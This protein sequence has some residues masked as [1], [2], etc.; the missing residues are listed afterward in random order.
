MTSG[1]KKLLR[2][3]VEGVLEHTWKVFLIALGLT[4]ISTLI[5]VSRFDIRSGL[6]DLMPESAK[7]VSDIESI[8]ARMGSITRLSI[9]LELTGE[10]TLADTAKD[11]PAYTACLERAKTL[12]EP[13]DARCED[14]LVIFAYALAER[15]ETLD[16][17][18]YVH[19]HNDKT[20]FE[21]NILLYATVEDL[22]ELYEDV[23]RKLDE[24]RKEIG[25]Y[26][27]CLITALEPDTQCVEPGS[28]GGGGDGEDDGYSSRYQDRLDESEVSFQGEYYETRLPDGADTL[29]IYVRFRNPS[30][31]YQETRKNLEGIEA[32][33]AEL[34]P[35]RFHPELVV[36]YGGGLKSQRD[37]YNSIIND[38]IFSASLTFGSIFLLIAFFFRRL[39]A[40][41][42]IMAPL[43]MS[44]SWTL[45]IAFSTVGYL[46]LITAFIF[47]VLLGLGI[48]FGIHILARYDEERSRGSDVGEAMTTA[49]V[50]VGSANLSGAITTSATFFT[51]M[52][53]DF[54]GFS[55]FGFVAGIGVLTALASMILVMPTVALLAHR[56]WPVKPRVLRADSVPTA[57]ASRRPVLI[58][59]S[60]VILLA[61]T[62][63]GSFALTHVDDVQLEDNFYRLRMRTDTKKRDRYA[64]TDKRHPSPA[65]LMLDTVD[66]VAH[67]ENR[68][69]KH[70]DPQVTW[71]HHQVAVT[72]PHLYT[73]LEQHFG[74]ALAMGGGDH[75]I[76]PIMATTT[77]I[78][79]H[80]IA[81]GKIVPDWHD[82]NA[83]GSRVLRDLRAFQ[84]AYPRLAQRL[85]EDFTGYLASH[86]YYAQ[87]FTVSLASSWYPEPLQ[88][89]VPTRY[90]SLQ[91][92][93]VTD[94]V[95]VFSFM[96][97]SEEEQLAKLE[98]IEKIR[99]R[100]RERR[101]RFLPP[102]DREE[103]EEL[104]TFLVEKPISVDDLPPWVKLQFRET[105]ATP[106]PPREGSGVD[107]AFGNVAFIYQNTGSLD[108][109]QTRRFADD[110]DRV[111]VHGDHVTLSA[112]ALVFSEII[113]QVMEDGVKLTSVVLL[114][115]I[116]V[117]LIQV[118][119][120]LR[121]IIVM[122]P[123][124]SSLLML[125]ACMEIFYIK[126]TFF[127]MVVL[128]MIIGIGIDDG[129]HLYHRY[130]EEG[131]G[132]IFFALRHTGG[133]IF[134]TSATTSIGFSGMIFSMH[135]G[136]N[137]MGE[138]A[139]L[140]IGLAW[141]ATMTVQP[142]LILLAE[143]FNL[144]SVVPEKVFEPDAGQASSHSG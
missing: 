43:L 75:G 124:F 16:F 77:Q 6:N 137:T 120:P 65:L 131:R 25:E 114:A 136:L 83:E 79:P 2:F 9:L 115:V 101:I 30:T 37:S 116:L 47:A 41:L 68:F 100:T 89:L 53:A 54:R 139:V 14:A 85:S 27:A 45:A 22:E 71:S 112:N 134:M 80:R 127:N 61:M 29:K 38:V 72:Y 117:V 12:E 56:A 63:V 128:P 57:H 62:G 140:G 50:E 110:M 119:S 36:G 73:F 87:L 8:T 132:S 138:L 46:N 28:G 15:I 11:H 122:A 129:I 142:A 143:R 59:L 13:A 78:L 91:L 106:A 82:Y 4:V 34:E 69:K 33:V 111:H 26:K 49:L 3:A 64:V 144:R 103:I 21:D 135:Q 90:D 67:M 102:K 76:A 125:I 118:R 5:V 58:G 24:K 97:G 10:H 35:T 95:S 98:V 70:R 105:G 133:S 19:F 123:L 113:D 141:L 88:R 109:A 32:L 17:I 99:K 40:V 66:D 51:L 130:T 108:G 81:R 7:S 121:A 96:P 1:S 23:D 48:D 93:S 31:S 84:Q 42:L 92:H 94:F 74:L 39:R 18:G 86:P 52:L 104:R 44:I 107:Y 20:F 60:V 126:I 55:Q